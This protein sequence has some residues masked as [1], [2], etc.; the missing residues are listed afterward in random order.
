M[1]QLSSYFGLLLGVQLLHSLEELTHGFNKRFPLFAMTFRFFLTFEIIFFLF[2]L[3]VFLVA[4]FPFR[5]GL[6]AFFI[7]LMFAN[8]IWHLVWWSIEK[9]YVPG[10]YSAPIFILVFLKF[11]FGVLVRLK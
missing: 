11:Y 3:T 1:D 4:S 5:A 7:L 9:K 2:W 6:M 8:G 10:L